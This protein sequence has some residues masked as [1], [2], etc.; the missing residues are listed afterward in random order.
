MAGFFMVGSEGFIYKGTGSSGGLIL[1]GKASGIAVIP[2]KAGR[3]ERRLVYFRSHGVAGAMESP[4]AWS[5]M[6]A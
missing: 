5:R 2:E 3:W 4:V 1:V 6:E